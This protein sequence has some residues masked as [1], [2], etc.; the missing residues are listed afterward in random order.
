MAVLDDKTGKPIGELQDF[1][2]SLEA[3]EQVNQ[4]TAGTYETPTGM[5][6]DPQEIKPSKSGVGVIPQMKASFVKDLDQKAQILAA[7]RFPNDPNAINRYGVHQGRLVYQDD[8]GSLHYENDD[9]TPSL[10]GM[11]AP[12]IGATVGGA[13]GSIPGAALGGSFG[14]SVNRLIANYFGEKQTSLGNAGDI[15][16]E[17]ALAGTGQ[18]L[19][20][21]VVDKMNAGSGY[22]AVPTQ[23]M[24][25]ARELKQKADEFGIPIDAADLTN[26]PRLKGTAHVLRMG[27]DEAAD[28]YQQ[29]DHLQN[30]RVIMAVDDWLNSISPN[31]EQVSAGSR[32]IDRSKEAI[33]D[34]KAARAKESS[35]HYTKA[36]QNDTVNPGATHSLIEKE[37]EGAK[38]STKL[39]LEKIRSYLYDDQGAADMS[40]KGLHNAKLEIDRLLN[41]N[42]AN[43][44]S[45]DNTQKRLLTEIKQSLVETLKQSEEYAKGIQKHTDLT[46]AVT[47][48]QENIVGVLSKL[49]PIQAESVIQK[50]YGAKTPNTIRQAKA[51]LQKKDPELWDDMLSSWLEGEFLQAGKPLISGEVVNIGPRFAQRL[52]NPTTKAKLYAAMS[53]EQREVFDKLMDVLSSLGRTPKG[54]SRTQMNQEVRQNMLSES[55]PVVGSGLNALEFWRVP[56]RVAEWWQ[57]ASL[58]EYSK[59]LALMMTDPD[60]LSKLKEITKLSP[61]S[62]KAIKAVGVSMA[63]VID[64]AVTATSRPYIEQPRQLSQQ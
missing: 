64:D 55:A 22:R 62:E 31:R 4:N 35:P 14:E 53:N 40:V 42:P 30:K 13:T 37:L 50:L 43:P 36:K 29:L 38:G 49:K 19:G 61:N 52:L 47:R 46:P 33:S 6:N 57:R 8:D 23:G 32:A 60:S 59:T 2:G 1:L 10:A 5:M 17:G 21:I 41:R 20:N 51:I 24:S 18:K 39:M 3:Q 56:S 34:A 28:I 25:E 54:G 26:S 48:L 12:A 7:A 11:V 15:A 58:G 27:T 44:D 45:L 16:I 63:T 9:F